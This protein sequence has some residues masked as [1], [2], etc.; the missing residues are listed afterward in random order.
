[1]LAIVV[2]VSVVSF[3]PFFA[4]LAPI[5]T[6]LAAPASRLEGGFGRATRP[7][8]ST[9]DALLRH[10]AYVVQQLPLDPAR[11]APCIRGVPVLPLDVRQ[12]GCPSA[13]RP[14]FAGEPQHDCPDSAPHH[15]SAK[16]ATR[17]MDKAVA[18]GASA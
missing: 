7:R 1:M 8:V 11:T 14:Q 10:A 3:A 2:I 16:P 18:K 4:R 9:P 6:R 15:L 5:R 13:N 17:L 12:C